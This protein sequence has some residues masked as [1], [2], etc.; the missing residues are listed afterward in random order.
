MLF[1][2]FLNRDCFQDSYPSTMIDNIAVLVLFFVY[3]TVLILTGLGIV[4]FPSVPLK[5]ATKASFV[6]K[7]ICRGTVEGFDFVLKRLRIVT[8]AGVSSQ[9]EQLQGT[10]WDYVL[11]HHDEDDDDSNSGTSVYDETMRSEQLRKQALVLHETLEVIEAVSVG[12]EKD[13]DPLCYYI[14]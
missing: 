11:Y 4:L 8:G 13:D 1:S 2:Q 14:E 6:L 9:I 5:W 10:R 7:C 12:D 3:E